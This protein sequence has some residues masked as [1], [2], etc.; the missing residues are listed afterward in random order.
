MKI[1]GLIGYPL[2]HSFSPIY[3]KKKFAKEKITNVSYESFPI[4]TIDEFPSL[5]RSYPNLGGVNVT[6]PY[7]E[8]IIPFLNELDAIAKAIGAVNTIDVQNGKLIGYN[9]DV[10]GFSV[11][12]QKLLQPFHQS[13]LILG[14]GG[15]S[16]A[17]AYSLKKLNIS[18]LFVTRKKSAA[19]SSSLLTYTDLTSDII[20]SHFLIINC[21]PIGMFPDINSCPQ[22]PYGALGKEHLLFDL[23]YNPEETLFMKKGKERGSAVCNGFEMLVSQAEK[24]WEIWSATCFD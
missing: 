18:F 2:S 16:K 5:I 21:T 3:F 9:T 12:L 15:A 7:K 10:H 24:S 14:T 23:V 8:T 4:A 19:S 20:K 17:I 13:A 11:S 22:L 6:I 1:F